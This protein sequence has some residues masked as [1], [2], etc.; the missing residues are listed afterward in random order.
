MIC[1]TGILNKNMGWPPHA[2]CEN[3]KRRCNVHRGE[4]YLGGFRIPLHNP[5]LDQLDQRGDVVKLCL[6]QDAWEQQGHVTATGEIRLMWLKWAVW[7]C[8]T[9]LLQPAPCCKPVYH[10]A[11]SWG[12]DQSKWGLCRWRRLPSHPATH[13]DTETS[14]VSTSYWIHG[15]FLSLSNSNIPWLL[16]DSLTPQT[17]TSLF[18]P[19]ALEFFSLLSLEYF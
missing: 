4:T 12:W 2:T 10:V 6:L 19:K 5:L 18:S 1:N 17:L 15:S 3:S 13:L 11:G 9:D 7:R 16:S 14:L 8:G